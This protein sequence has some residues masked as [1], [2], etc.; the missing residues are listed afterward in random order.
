MPHELHGYG[1]ILFSYIPGELFVRK[2]GVNIVAVIYYQVVI[3][4]IWYDTEIIELGN[5]CE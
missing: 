5:M 4:M 3:Y 2:W 1:Y